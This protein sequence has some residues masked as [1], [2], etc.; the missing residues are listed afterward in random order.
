MYVSLE[1]DDVLQDKA[2]LRVITTTI[3]PLPALTEKDTDVIHNVTVSTPMT[4]PASQSTPKGTS[5]PSTSAANNDSFVSTSD[6]SEAENSL[7]ISG[8]SVMTSKW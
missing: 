2:K 5:T 6:L 4:R 7:E 1:E 8:I 3:L